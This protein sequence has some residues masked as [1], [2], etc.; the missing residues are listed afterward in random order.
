MLGSTEYY[1]QPISPSEI[2]PGRI[3]LR[4]KSFQKG[5]ELISLKSRA[6]IERRRVVTVKN[7]YFVQEP[8]YLDYT[9]PDLLACVGR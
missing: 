9:L 1:F 4:A 6:T 7:Y 5:L 3:E 8:I 2:T